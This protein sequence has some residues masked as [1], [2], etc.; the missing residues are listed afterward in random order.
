MTY[1][2]DA[3]ASQALF[4]RAVQVT[5]GGVN[6]PVR[7]FKAVG[8]TPRFMVSGR[9]PYLTDAD[10]RDYVDLVCSWG[11]MLLGHAH[12]EVQAAVQAARQQAR[13]LYAR[14]DIV[15]DQLNAGWYGLFAIE[16]MAYGKP[17]VTHLDEEGKLAGRYSAEGII[18]G[19]NATP[20]DAELTVLRS[21]AAILEDPATGSA[22]A[23][24][25]GWFCTTRPGVDVKRAVSQ[26][27]AV[28]RPSTLFL[29]VRGGTIFVGGD[30]V[31]LG[32]GSFSL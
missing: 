19:Y 7:A 29:E 25:G 26:G 30:V 6:S 9:G 13:E 16:S 3:P 31:E 10:G 14:A 12:P 24:L 18:D 4:D 11:P 17:V 5:P 22:C 1:P 2:Y 23:N 28:Q 8:G 15:V 20:T 32:A 27:E 21:G